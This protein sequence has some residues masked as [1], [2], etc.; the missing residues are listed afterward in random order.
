VKGTGEFVS[1]QKQNRI[2]LCLLSAP[3]K[4][5]TEK[6]KYLLVAA[7]ANFYGEILL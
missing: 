7:D 3:L 6:G 1:Q 4:I 2:C 5:R